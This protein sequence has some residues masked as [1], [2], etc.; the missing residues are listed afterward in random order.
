MM[1]TSLG[2]DLSRFKRVF[3]RK[4]PMCGKKNT[5]RCEAIYERDWDVRKEVRLFVEC[6]NCRKQVYRTV[7]PIDASEETIRKAQDRD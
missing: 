3:D 7:L 4:C 5:L 1:P 2:E 6:S